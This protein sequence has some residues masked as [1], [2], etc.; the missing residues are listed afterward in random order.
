MQGA[1]I[2]VFRGRFDP[3]SFIEFVQ[4]R[5][6]RLQLDVVVE[7]TGADRI[8]VAVSGP[9]DL[10]DAFE[11]ACSLGPIDCLVREVERSSAA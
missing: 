11:M 9:R 7:R 5:A 4:H 6:R 3:E 1:T 2:I 10:V 8:D